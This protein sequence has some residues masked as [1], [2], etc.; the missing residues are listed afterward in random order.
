M[1][2]EKK[3]LSML[4]LA[5]RAGRV[6]SGEFQTEK[7]VKT[8]RAFLVIVAEDAS[9]NTRKMFC[10]MCR[11]HEVP[12]QYFSTKE[13]LGHA[14]GTQMRASAAVTDEGFAHR[15]N[16]M[17]RIRRESMAQIPDSENDGGREY[18]DRE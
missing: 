7:A 12:L 9:E 17:I 5:K 14:I 18:G 6:M 16:E 2:P 4:G 10:D 1:T 3:I 15:I 13:I 11:Y 8:G